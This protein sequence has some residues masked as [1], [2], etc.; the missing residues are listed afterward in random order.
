MNLWKATGTI[1]GLTMVSRILG[2][3]REMV[4]ARV[5]GAS[6]AA[7]VFTLAFLI[8]NLFR[9]LFGE[10]AFSAGLRPALQP[11]AEGRRRQRGGEALREEILAVFLPLLLVITAIFM[12][13][14]PLFIGL[15]VGDE[16][17]GD[18][19]GKPGS[20]LR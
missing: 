10:G 3:V 18:A 11:A 15:I 9:R 17:G 20:R 6:A 2:F 5:L 14:M 13:F 7:D 19:G 12:I 8:P 4:V 1:G 16:W